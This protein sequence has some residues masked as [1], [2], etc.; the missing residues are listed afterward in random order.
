MIRN[1]VQ[2]GLSQGMEQFHWSVHHGS[3]RCLKRTVAPWIKINPQS[4]QIGQF[5][6]KIDGPEVMKGRGVSKLAALSP[7][8]RTC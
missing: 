4:A 6:F 1:R 3:G 8:F 5:R 2:N 7:N